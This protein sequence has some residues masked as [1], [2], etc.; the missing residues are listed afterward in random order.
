MNRARFAIAA[1][2]AAATVAGTPLLAQ[3]PKAPEFKSILA[4]RK[5]D[6]PIK[7]QAE[8]D[9]MQPVTKRN[10]D[11]VTT[12]IRIK[13]TS[14]GPIARLTVAETWFDKGGAIVGGG[15]GYLEKILNPGAVDTVTIQTPWNAKM[16]GN[17]WNFTHANG[18]V[19]PRRVPKIEE[20][21]AAPAAGAGAKPVAKK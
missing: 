1:A 9:F 10:G 14:P 15:Q 13:N 4:N 19:K 2:L 16:N 5:V 17:S 3:A 21:K 20:G 12:T 7:G 18:T 6:P 8:V 11:V